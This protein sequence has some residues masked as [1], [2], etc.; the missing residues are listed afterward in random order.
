MSGQKSS[1]EVRRFIRSVADHKGWIV[2][3]EPGF[4]EDLVEGFKTNFS[5]YGFFQCPCRDSYG[6]RTKDK[7]IMCPCEYAQADIDEYGQCFCGL[8]L[9][10][11][12][13]DSHDEIDGIPERRPDELYPE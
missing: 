13:Y 9:A 6:D 8:F 1:D 10:P 7:D 12:F 5:R 2:N 4:V 3:R 11:D